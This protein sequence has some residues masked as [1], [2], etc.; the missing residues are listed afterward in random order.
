MPTLALVLLGCLTLGGEPS[1]PAPT[2]LYVRTAPPGANVA[3]D[4]KRLGKSDAIFSVAPGTQT[5]LVELDGFL[6]EERRVEIRAEE[7]TRVDLQL[8]RLPET[9]GQTGTPASPSAG[10]IDAEKNDDAVS[11]AANAY[12]AEA[13]LPVPVRDAMLVVLRQHPTENRWS[14][15]AGTTLFGIAVK[16]LPR[17][18][19]RQQA[20]PSM[21]NLTGML[22]FQ[23]LLKA[24][25]LLDRYATVGLTDATTLARAVMESA[26]ELQ[27]KGN[28]STILQG[29]AVQGGCAVA[30][31]TAEE[32]ALLA[33]LLQETELEKVRSAYRDVMHRQARELMQ[34]SNWTDALLLWQHLHKRKLVSQQI[35]LDAASCFQ[36]L[37]KVP[38]MLRVLTEAIDTF[39]KNA[40]PEFLEK[41]GDMALAIETEQSQTLAEK[42]YRMASEQLKETIS[43]GPEHAVKAEQER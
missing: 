33:T 12:L 11:K 6:P 8:R 39:G 15:R 37:N 27:V 26:G 5:V 19:V 1:A 17:G 38:D 22:A 9:A 28:A 24:K 10:T 20:V 25:S 34:R 16:R 7:V 21:L 4:G 31:A 14:G 40:A 13:D 43:S 2:R 41:A 30:Y 23:E 35:Y 29:A 32:K 18:S 3:L 36:H 42:A